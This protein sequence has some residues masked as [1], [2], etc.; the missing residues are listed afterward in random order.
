MT[1]VLGAAWSSRGEVS[2]LGGAKL[3]LEERFLRGASA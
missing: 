2:D 1:S 3:L